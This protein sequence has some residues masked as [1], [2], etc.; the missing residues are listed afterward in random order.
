VR[1]RDGPGHVGDGLGGEG[2]EESLLEH[3]LHQRRLHA[4]GRTPRGQG[5]HSLWGL[6]WGTLG[7]EAT[8]PVLPVLCCEGINGRGRPPR[9]RGEEK[10]SARA[11][12]DLHGW[13]E[14]NAHAPLAGR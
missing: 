14:M 8:P 10:R 9:P 6:M 1:G 12:C 4:G 2:V 13:L 11:P 5:K 7:L 3:P